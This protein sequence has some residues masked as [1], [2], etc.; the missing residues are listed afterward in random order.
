M[1]T[2][3]IG[4][5]TLTQTVGSP[6]YYARYRRDGRQIAR[7]LKT[8]DITKAVSVAGRPPCYWARLFW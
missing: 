7:S 1:L 8:E 4:N 3:R 2:E 5:V 6:Y